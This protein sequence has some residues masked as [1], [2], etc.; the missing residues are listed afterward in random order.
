MSGKSSSPAAWWSGLE[1]APK[2]LFGARGDP[3]DP[4]L[5][6][7]VR[8]WDGNGEPSWGKAA[9]VGFPFDEGVRRNRGRPG[10]AGAPD[11]IREGLYRLTPW[12]APT[13]VD[14]ATLEITDLGNV[15]ADAGLEAAQARLGEAVGAVLCGGAAVPVVLGGGHETALGH[16]LGYAAADVECGVINIDAHL[17]VRPCPQGAHSGS[18]FRQAIE[19]AVHPLRA[20]RYV[21]IGAQRQCV[22]RA[23]AEYVRNHG[24]RVYWLDGK[25]DADSVRDAFSAELDRL[26]RDAGAVLVTVDADAFRQADVPGCSAPSPFG[27]DGALGPEIAYRAGAHPHVRSIDFVE[28]NPA[29]DRDGQTIRWTAQCLRQ[30]LVGRAER[31]DLR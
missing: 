24:G 6:E 12:D 21:V 16:Y 26:G 13:G 18:P 10:A 11:A 19:H 29:L 1:P 28:V 7:T 27:L 30:F 31:S 2:G 17:D 5:G 9:L 14:L 3:Q 25:V 20:G 15:R 22:A 4:R 23:H 8:G